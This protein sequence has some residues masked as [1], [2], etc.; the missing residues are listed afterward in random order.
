MQIV[1]AGVGDHAERLTLPDP[2][3]EVMPGVWWG[4]AS[5]VNTPAYWAARCRWEDE[6]PRFSSSTSSLVEEIGFC[7]LG[8]FGIRYEMNK[9]AFDLLKSVDAFDEARPLSEDD[10]RALLLRP[11]RIGG[12]EQRYRFPNQRAR[13]IAEMMRR[14]V[15]LRL[16]ELDAHD[17]R[18]ALIELEG[19]GPKTAS[20]IVRNFLDSDAVAII[21]IHLIRACKGMRVFPEVVSLPRDYDSLE[22]RFIEFA[23]AIAVRPSILD[24]VI[25]TEMRTHR[26]GVAD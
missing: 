12:G 9:A 21:D 11:L 13:R 25:W 8:G 7:L 15:D 2:D 18:G 16:H 19:I 5:V 17:L 14:V 24:A 20:W 23:H 3:V 1:W 6:L 26:V 22:R 4:P 10:L